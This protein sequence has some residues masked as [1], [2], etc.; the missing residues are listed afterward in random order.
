MI[1]NNN[2]R[3]FISLKD[4]VNE[5]TFLN[6][7]KEEVLTPDLGRMILKIL[8]SNIICVFYIEKG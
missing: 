4:T 1:S 6:S 3:L 7:T 8:A 2:Y 5:V